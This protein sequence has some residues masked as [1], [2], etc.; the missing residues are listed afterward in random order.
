MAF[1]IDFL[2]KT[3]FIKEVSGEVTDKFL[4]TLL[5][6]MDQAFSM[7]WFFKTFGLG[8]YR[9]NI[10]GFKGKYLFTTKDGSVAASAIFSP[11]DMEVKGEEIQDW[12]VK[13]TFKDAA[14]L[15]GFMFSPKQDILDSVLKNEVTVAGNLN[16]I[17]KFGFM[18]RDLAKKFGMV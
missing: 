18:E 1:G 6:A 13:I 10:K 3:G 5:H 9:K 15:R 16:Y 17:F 7:D 12:D 14:A 8:S 2:P 4:E 11:G